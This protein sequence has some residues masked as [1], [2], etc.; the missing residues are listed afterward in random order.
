LKLSEHTKNF[1]QSRKLLRQFGAGSGNVTLPVHPQ[2]YVLCITG[3]GGG[4]GGGHASA[5]SDQTSN[6]A[7]AGGCGGSSGAYMKNFMFPITNKV[8]PLV[9]PWSVGAGSPGA[10]SVNIGSTSAGGNTSFGDYFILPGG[11]AAQYRGQDIGIFGINFYMSIYLGP[12][13]TISFGEELQTSGYEVANNQW[14]NWGQTMGGSTGSFWNITNSIAYA[15]NPPV[16][17]PVDYVT[18]PPYTGTLN[19]RQGGWGASGA[20]GRGG[21]PTSGIGGNASGYGAGGAGGHPGGTSGNQTPLYGGG[22]GSPGFLCIDILIPHD[23]S[24]QYVNIQEDQL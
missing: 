22:A 15:A 1:T 17:V 4:S 10:T 14:R 6:A 24:S 19:Q 3:C 20:F 21:A 2:T 7:G 5:R 9:V 13:P 11:H 12:L 16:G 23:F 8:S 18:Y